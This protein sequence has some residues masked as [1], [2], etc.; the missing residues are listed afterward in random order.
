MVCKGEVIHL[1]HFPLFYSKT[2]KKTLLTSKSLDELKG[3]SV[4]TEI[5][6]KD[7]GLCS[8]ATL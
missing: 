2:L 1:S 5:K 3:L 4:T 7:V 8:A 6:K